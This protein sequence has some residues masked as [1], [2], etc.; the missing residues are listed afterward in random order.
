MSL[1]FNHHAASYLMPVISSTAAWDLFSCTPAACTQ[2]SFT[3][4]YLPLAPILNTAGWYQPVLPAPTTLTDSGGWQRWTNVAG[5]VAQQ[6][7]FGAELTLMYS[8]GAIAQSS[9]REQLDW[10]WDGTTFV[11][12]E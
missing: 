7:T 2:A 10:I 9:V 3:D 12:P 11:N 5:L 4:A 1:H 6:T 8:P